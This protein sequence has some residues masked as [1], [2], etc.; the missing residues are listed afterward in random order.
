MSTVICINKF[1]QQIKQQQAHDTHANLLG[2]MG[3]FTD[4]L[5]EFLKEKII[6]AKRNKKDQIVFLNF[7]SLKWQSQVG[8]EQDMKLFVSCSAS[9]SARNVTQKFKESNECVTDNLTQYFQA[10]LSK[11]PHFLTMLKDMGKLANKNKSRYDKELRVGGN[12]AYLFHVLFKNILR[13]TYQERKIVAIEGLGS[14][15]LSFKIN[16]KALARGSH[17]GYLQFEPMID[18]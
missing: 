13:I 11:H 8:C 4:L 9:S 7:W 17:L 10:V 18:L 5:G 16:K 12:L 15:E 2:L 1:T 14:F 6:D 3:E